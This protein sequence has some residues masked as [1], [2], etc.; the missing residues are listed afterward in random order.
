MRGDLVKLNK[1]LIIISGVLIA[2]MIIV[3]VITSRVNEPEVIIVDDMKNPNGYYG[4][5]GRFVE[6]DKEIKYP[7]IGKPVDGK[8]YNEVLLENKS[9]RNKTTYEILY[10][11]SDNM[12]GFYVYLDYD[13]S[14]GLVREDNKFLVDICEAN[15]YTSYGAYYE[16][17]MDYYSS[18]EEE[19]RYYILY[20]FDGE[21]EY[22][23]SPYTIIKSDSV[24]YL[25]ERKYISFEEIQSV[26]NDT[27]TEN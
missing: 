11:L 25:P 15:P 20:E 5:N 12:Y 17:D 13:N 8:L 9:F 27:T 22:Q 4:V 19:I 21:V 6:Y 16:D 24:E 3:A 14:Y 2:L 18:I 23:E 1:I 10:K 26:V 7:E